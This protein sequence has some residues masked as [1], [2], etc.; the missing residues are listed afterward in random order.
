[1]TSM[2][3]ASSAAKQLTPYKLSLLVLLVTIGAFSA[4]QPSY[5][6]LLAF[7][8]QQLL[9]STASLMLETC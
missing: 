6:G 7:L 5:P 1:M 4:E 9:V 8:V 2:A 3:E